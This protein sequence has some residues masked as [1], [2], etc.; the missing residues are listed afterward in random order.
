MAGLRL[1]AHP[2]RNV[3]EA[4]R[5]PIWA[6]AAERARVRPLSWLGLVAIFIAKD[7]GQEVFTRIGVIGGR[8][9]RLLGEIAGVGVMVGIVWAHRR[10]RTVVHLGPVLMAGGRCPNCGYD[11]RGQPGRCPECGRAG[12]W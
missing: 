4:E 6:A 7:V 11:R 10:R 12:P 8:P 3:P 1:S 9:D 5:R 2:L